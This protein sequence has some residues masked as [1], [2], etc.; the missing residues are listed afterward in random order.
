MLIIIINIVH[1]LIILYVLFGWVINNTAFLTLHVTLCISLLTHWYSNSDMCS[2]T[3]L[4]SKLRG[5][6]YNGAFT[7][8]IVSPIYK[9]SEKSWNKIAYLITILVLVISLYKLINHKRTRKCWANNNMIG[10]IM[11]LLNP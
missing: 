8:N 10:F 7:Y 3:L 2:L 1:I 5:I 6:P 11:C 4:E 9:I